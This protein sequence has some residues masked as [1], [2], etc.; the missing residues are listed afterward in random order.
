MRQNKVGREKIK[1]H[2]YDHSQGSVGAKFETVK[3]SPV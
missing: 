1:L 2:V 3:D